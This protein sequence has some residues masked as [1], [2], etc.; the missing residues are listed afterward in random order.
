LEPVPQTEFKK[1]VS[2]RK[3]IDEHMLNRQINQSPPQ[4]ISSL[5]YRGEE[6]Y[7]REDV[8]VYKKILMEMGQQK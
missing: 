8:E 1:K 2:I 7:S 3:S 4:E 6:A 5:M